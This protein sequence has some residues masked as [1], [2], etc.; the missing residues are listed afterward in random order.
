MKSYILNMNIIVNQ[1]IAILPYI[2]I[3]LCI[4]DTDFNFI[5]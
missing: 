3:Q 4:N 5:K 1:T 2:G